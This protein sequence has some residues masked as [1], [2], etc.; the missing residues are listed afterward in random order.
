MILSLLFIS[1]AHADPVVVTLNKG[2]TAPF[3]GTLFNSDAT[4]AVLASSSAEE[5]RCEIKK[6]LEIK[7]A[8]SLIEKDKE[9]V[10]S[11]LIS[12]ENSLS[13]LEKENIDLTKKY[14]RSL[15]MRPYVATTG[16]VGGVGLTI[17]IVSAL[18]GTQ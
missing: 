17:L 10:E 3:T 11:N 15:A 7:S 4:A 2:E 14:N 13:I 6:D 9:I 16:F 18:G 5:K 1:L 8:T 12:C